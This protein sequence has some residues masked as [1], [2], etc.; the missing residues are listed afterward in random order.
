MKGSILVLFFTS[1]GILLGYFDLNPDFFEHGN[2]SLYVLY[3][4]L[5]LVGMGL[6]FDI[7]ALL[8]LREMRLNILFI[9]L[10]LMC[11]SLLFGALAGILLGYTIYDGMVIASGVGYYSLASILVTETGNTE[12]ASL[13][14]LANMFREVITLAFPFVLVKY[15]GKISPIMVSGAAAMDT[16]LPSIAK[17]SGE[18]FALV[19]IFT[20]VVLTIIV[21]LLLPFL[22]TLI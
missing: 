12:L 21:P 14:L 22:L 17:F 5:F 20:G 11:G 9:P 2:M 10:G 15:F 8:V 7:K 4:M 19:G 1:L 16:C 6:G 18:K 13:T 3:V